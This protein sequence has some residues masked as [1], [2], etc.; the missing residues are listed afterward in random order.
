MQFCTRCVL[1][2]TTPGIVFDEQGICNYCRDYERMKVLGEEKLLSIIE[3]FR[4]KGKKYDCMVCISGGRDS[5][6]TLWKVVNDY[7]LKVLAVNYK[8][9]FTSPQASDNM[10]TAIKLLGIDFID[11]EFPNDIHRR[12]TT[13]ALKVWAVNPTSALIPIVC[14]HCKTIWPTLFKVARKH[15]IPL[16]IVGS[17]P[18][19]TAS[20][21]QASLGGARYYHKLSRLPQLVSKSLKELIKNPK[22]LKISWKLVLKMYLYAGHNSPLLR[23]RFSDIKVIRLFDYLRWDENMVIST[24]AKNLNWKKSGEVESSWRFD[25]RLDYVRRKM[26]AATVGV[27]EL[28]DLFS[29]MIREGMLSR[30]EAEFRLLSEDCIPNKIADSVLKDLGMS[31]LDLN[32]TENEKATVPV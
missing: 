16:I 25:C 9:P 10:S 21:K 7:K 27:T 17:N 32:L 29:K 20:F 31:T 18:L 30:Q 6:Y 12:H 5:T 24:I 1:T 13:K 2:S 14:A 11:W 28:R 8:N 26:Y 23:T 4:G 22:Y 19:E 15:E 3:N